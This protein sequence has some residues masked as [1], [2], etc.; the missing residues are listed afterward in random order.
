MD[1]PKYL[2]D[3]QGNLLVFAP[4]T[5]HVTMAIRTGGIFVSGGFMCA[6][7]TPKGKF[8]GESV[9]TKLLANKALDWSSLTWFQGVYDRQ[10]IFGT[11]RELLAKAGAKDIQPTTWQDHDGLIFP[12]DGRLDNARL[13]TF[14]LP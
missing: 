12:S 4:A 3:D 10:P 9:S 7:R 11:D 6:S 1:F 13:E 8:F 14:F 5:Q 2:E